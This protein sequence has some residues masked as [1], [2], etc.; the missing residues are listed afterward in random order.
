MH[1]EKI[2]DPLVTSLFG[3]IRN[4]PTDERRALLRTIDGRLRGVRA[5]SAEP[6]MPHGGDRQRRTASSRRDKSRSRSRSNRRLP[7]STTYAACNAGGSSVRTAGTST[8]ASRGKPT[9]GGLSQT[10]LPSDD[11]ILEE[12]RRCARDLGPEFGYDEYRMWALALQ[13]TNPDRPA[14]L[15]DASDLIG[16]FGSYPRARIAAGLERLPRR[17]AEHDDESSFVACVSAVQAAA[18]DIGGIRI[19]SVSEYMHWRSAHLEDGR[20]RRALASPP[21]WKVISDRFGTWPRALAAAGLISPQE[22]ADYYRGEG[23]QA[24]DAHIARWLCVAATE[25]GPGMAID[26]YRAW[27]QKQIKDPALA[28]PPSRHDVQQRLGSWGA[29]V[30]ATDAALKT[31]DPFEHIMGILHARSTTE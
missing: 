5:Q 9:V 24:S 1:D 8:S 6:A 20:G 7:S 28:Y 19:L 13:V 30:Q 10:L 21:G 12:M 11:E 23:E 26:A 18:D 27:R 25:L 17:L 4:L 14:P 3:V 31:S 16:R 22:A 2:V 29:A 15:F